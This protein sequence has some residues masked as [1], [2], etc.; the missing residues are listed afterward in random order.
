MNT[1]ETG[2]DAFEQHRGLLQGI[3]YRMCGTLADA[4]DIV[5]DTYLKWSAAERSTIRDPRAWLVTVCARLAMDLAKSARKRREKYVGVWLPDPFPEP[6][7]HFSP[8]ARGQV[9]DSVS[10]A[11]MLALER[12]TPVERAAFL[13]HDVFGYRFDE[14]A[15]VLGKSEALSRKAA[16]R[17]RKAV[18]ENRPRFAASPETHRRLLDA[19]LEAARAGEP[20]PL[21][22]LLAESAELHS[23]GGGRVKTAPGVLRGR[24]AVAGFFL[25]V[26]RKNVPSPESLRV[27]H[28]WFN[29]RPGALLYLR[30]RLVAALSLALEGDAITRVFTLRN[31]DK[32]ALFGGSSPP[33]QEQPDRRD[34]S[35]VF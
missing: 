31:P 29:G 21:M 23:D 12:L 22:S 19:F 6:D 14:I 3:A 17:A 5:Q 13:L 9:D 10:I 20:E 30:G 1:R 16:S 28:R 24:D 7:G 32:L 4:Q 18:R 11:L 15:R 8:A 27:V 2:L 25:E 34:D 33:D 26:L 35:P